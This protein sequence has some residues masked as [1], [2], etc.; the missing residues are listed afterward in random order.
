LEELARWWVVARLG[1]GDAVQGRVELAISGA[2][3]PMPFAV[4]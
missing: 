2:R 4:A 1:D 3:Q